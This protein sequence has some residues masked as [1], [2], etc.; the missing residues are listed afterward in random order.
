MKNCCIIGIG[1]ALS[2]IYIIIIFT[3]AKRLDEKTIKHIRKKRG[4]YVQGVF[5]S[6]VSVIGYIVCFI[7][8]EMSPKGAEMISPVVSAGV[9]I[10]VWKIIDKVYS[11]MYCMRDKK[12]KKIRN[13]ERQLT[14][15]DK[16]L[17]NTVGMSG[18]IICGLVM[19][20]QEK[21]W[22]YFG[23][24]SMAIGIWIG[25]FISIQSIQS[26]HTVQAV[27]EGLKQ[28]FGEIDKVI[29]VIS[30][31]VV[32]SIVCMSSLRCFARVQEVVDKLTLGFGI[33]S[34]IFVVGLLVKEKMI[35]DCRKNRHLQ[36]R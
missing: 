23:M 31:L 17:C 36:R 34:V 33:G 20:I 22:S 12:T 27:K 15:Q 5:F 8:S 29:L 32:A 21:Q 13:D 2:I 18:L 30:I 1:I 19:F 10:I 35:K 3:H 24:C 25:A 26:D 9:L 28:N 16:N 7:V 4:K 11:G 6:L 14:H